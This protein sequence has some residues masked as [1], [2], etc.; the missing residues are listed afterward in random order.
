MLI[1]PTMSCYSHQKPKKSSFFFPSENVSGST[2]ISIQQKWW[3]HFFLR[4][5]CT[6]D[7]L[8]T[9]FYVILTSLQARNWRRLRSGKLSKSLKANEGQSWILNTD[10][11]DAK[12]PV[13]LFVCLFPSLPDAFLTNSL[14]THSLWTT[15]FGDFSLDT[16]ASLTLPR[17]FHADKNTGRYILPLL[18]ATQINTQCSKIKSPWSHF[19]TCAFFWYV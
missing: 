17:P 7:D 19:A 6:R 16:S 11:Q 12:S 14:V 3:G 1:L 2:R 4:M 10:G 15:K 18:P 9:L 8:E 13:C 5:H